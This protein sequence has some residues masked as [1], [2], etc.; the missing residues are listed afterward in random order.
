MFVHVILTA[1]LTLLLQVTGLLTGTPGVSLAAALTA[2]SMTLIDLAKLKDPSGQIASI[3][4]L[5]SQTNE[6]L[7]DMMWM[8]GNLD[9]GHRTTVRTG[10][11][12]PTWRL[13]N[14][15]VT[16]TKGT[17]AQIDE[18]CGMLEAWSQIDTELANLGGNPGAVR[19]SQARAHI[20]AMGQELAQT[21][22]YGSSLAPNEFIGLAAR[23]NLSTAGNGDNLILTGGTGSTDNTSVY[24]IAWDSETVTGIVPKGSTAGLKHEDLGVETLN[25]AGGSAGA[26][27]R[28]YRDRFVW[29]AGI[30]LKDWRYV[31]RLANID[32]SELEEASS[33]PDLLRYMADAEMRLPSNLGRRAFYMNRTVAR[34]LRRQVTAAVSS[35]G[36]L[37][38]ENFAGKR[39]MMFGTTPVRIVDALTNTEDVV[40]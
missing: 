22:F 10:L 13:L 32:V 38:F 6:I 25:D 30:A 18:Q 34:N 35:G 36:G 4:E 28:V 40:A 2:T 12:T 3:V 39:V 19:L 31:V 15:G 27:L 5:M 33:S 7:D 26:L 1:V 21:V 14:Q 11:P 8:E 23:Y 37:T 17:T 9:T 29:K 24:L 16:P 20:E